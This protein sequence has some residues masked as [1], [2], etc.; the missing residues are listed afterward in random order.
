M[1]FPN[2]YRYKIPGY[3]KDVFIIPHYKIQNYEFQ[4][5]AGDDEDGWEHVSVVVQPKSKKATRCPTWEE[6]CFI[7]DQFWKENQEVVQ[8]HPAKSEYVS[9]HDFCL[10]LWRPINQPLISP[11]K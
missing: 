4:C 10:H 6:M 8:F 2:Q 9:A 5:I 3:P 11:N 1:L 7:K